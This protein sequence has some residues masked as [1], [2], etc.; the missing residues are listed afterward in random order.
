MEINNI[1]QAKYHIK[2]CIEQNEGISLSDKSIYDITE[3]L[4]GSVNRE[5]MGAI[6]N[7]RSMQIK[8]LILDKKIKELEAFIAKHMSEES[9]IHTTYSK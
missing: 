8:N 7:M 2:H 1:T 6:N 3:T 4:I 5:I 9:Q